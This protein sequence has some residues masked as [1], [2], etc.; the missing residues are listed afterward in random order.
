MNSP[1]RSAGKK[2]CRS[3]KTTILIV[4]DQIMLLSLL[5][6]DLKL[7]LPECRII[8]AVDGADG[9]AKARQDHPD[10]IITD[11][12][13]PKLDGYEMLQTMRQEQSCKQ[14]PV[15]GMSANEPDEAKTMAFRNVCDEFLPKPLDNQELLKK[16]SRLAL[17]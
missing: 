6:W 16:I 11:L 13:M 15:I 1:G 17:G 3:N 4:E 12:V 14:I 2:G 5:S 10:L 7:Q 8:T 9:L